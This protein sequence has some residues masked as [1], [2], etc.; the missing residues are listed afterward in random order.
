MIKRVE[1]PRRGKKDLRKKERT[2]NP[3][4]SQRQRE[5]NLLLK[6]D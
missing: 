2:V 1:C 3:G 6:G 5:K 4:L